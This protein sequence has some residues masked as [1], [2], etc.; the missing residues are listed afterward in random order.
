TRPGLALADCRVEV[1]GRRDLEALHPGREGLLVVSL[2]EQMQVIALDAEMNDPEA[3]SPGGR[4]RGFADRLVGAAATQIA[5][6]A[7]HAQHDVNRVARVE[8]WPLLVW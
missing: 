3:F 7:D 6:R 5:N 1:L 2:D 4:E 8:E